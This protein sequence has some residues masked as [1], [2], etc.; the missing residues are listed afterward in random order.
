VIILGLNA[1]HGDS[2]ACLV[3]DGR[4][5]AA[6]E[7]ERFTRTKHWAGFPAQSVR[8]CL[9]AAGVR[10]TDLDH[11]AV[12][13]N[14]S[15][16]LPRKVLFTLLGRPSLSVLKDRGENRHRVLGIGRTLCEAVG[17]DPA[18]LRAPVHFVE[19]HRAHIASSFL[20]S[21]FDE[22][23][24]VSVDGFGDF[25]ST[26]IARG[27][28]G[29][30]R[31]ERVIPFP[32]SLGAFYTAGS[33]YLGFPSF[34]DEYKVMGLAPYGEPVD[35][36]RLRE[37]IR[38]D[39]H[40]LFTL[41]TRWFRHP[42]EVVDVRWDGGAP[43]LGAYF[44]ER[45]AEVFGP[46]REAGAPIEDRHRNLARSLQARLEEVYRHL[47]VGAANGTELGTLCLSGGCAYNSVAN[48]LALTEAPFTR[49]YVPPAAGDAGT[50]VGA[51]YWVWNQM[52]GRPRTF[53]LDSAS[54]GPEYTAER[55]RRAVDDAGLTCRWIDDEGE[56][57]AATVERL[58]A[59]DVV[60]W[61][62][63]REEW[64]PRAL[65]HRS[66]LA[67]PRR[68][69]M[70]DIL[71]ER[72]KRRESFRPFAPSILGDRL[73]DYFDDAHPSP[74]MTQT[75]RVKAARRAEIPAVTHVDGSARPQ[76]VTREANPLFEKLLRTFGER[77]G[78]PVLLNTSFN[79]NEPI[80]HSPEEA[81]ACFRRTR[82]DVLVLG[83]AFVAR[84][85][86]PS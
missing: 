69:D 55:I 2:A 61:F 66:I 28:G 80:V 32:H 47:L 67:D 18:S 70:K 56:R 8:W 10:L 17:A 50:A 68:A 33:Q 15:A 58:V 82:M 77:T 65:G 30:I 6:V 12:G 9:E 44:S 16:H 35:L 27:R 3:V 31:V 4:L 83:S 25:V 49:L 26:M 62:Q 46:P 79:E 38:L 81:I 34:G 57:V 43:E 39:A 36:E 85:R 71:N 63:G 13:R 86:A 52:L 24:C 45:W 73:S 72:I 21:P 76:T 22:A 74:F 37:V 19:H 11:V 40:G 5:V 29:R 84:G 54:V 23:V 48:G 75:Y 59:G 41:D 51:A 78:T 7:E 53:T 20:V 64:G 60:G 1:Y 14:P 42:R